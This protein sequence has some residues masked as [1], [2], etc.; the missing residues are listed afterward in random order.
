MKRAFYLSSCSTCKKILD[1]LQLPSHYILQDI[2]NNEIT[3]EQIEEMKSRANSYEAL[4]SRRARKYQNMGLKDKE[5]TEKD[6]KK[7]IL[8]DYTF[9]KRPVFIHESKIF[10]G[11][12]KKTVA[13][14]KECINE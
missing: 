3:D 12:S 1:Q 11:N 5:L 6:Y 2:K 13:A 14:L 9:L 8:E 10:I 7:L 4:F